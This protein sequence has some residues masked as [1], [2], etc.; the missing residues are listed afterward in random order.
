VLLHHVYAADN[1]S[2]TIQ[3]ATHGAALSLVFSG[4]HDHFVITLELRHG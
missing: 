4:Y 1:D 3:D 2:V